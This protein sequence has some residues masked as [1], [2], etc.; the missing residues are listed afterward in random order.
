VRVHLVKHP[1]EAWDEAVRRIADDSV[2][3]ERPSD[4]E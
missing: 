3:T 2:Q 1:A 4:D